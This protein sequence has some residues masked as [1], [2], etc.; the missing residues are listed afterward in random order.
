MASRLPSIEQVPK[1]VSSRMTCSGPYRQRSEDIPGVISWVLQET[2]M[3]EVVRSAE[4]TAVRR[5]GSSEFG[6]DHVGVIVVWG[7]GRQA[8][9]VVNQ[10]DGT[11]A[12]GFHRSRNV[13]LRGFQR[14]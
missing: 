13:P 9:L 11:I 3:I 4:E 5:M 8:R 12:A 1:M 6:S 14:P 7:V 10:M 2:T